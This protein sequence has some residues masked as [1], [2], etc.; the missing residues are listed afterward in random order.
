[1]Y[2]VLGIKTAI[3][4]YQRIMHHPD[5]LK[6]NVTTAFLN[7]TF[8]TSDDVREHPLRD[9]ALIATA[10]HEYERLSSTSSPAPSPTSAPGSRW[11]SIGRNEGLQS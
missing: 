9:I 2:Q 11:K 6:G 5:F 7:E 10:I 3:P 1:E 8:S 4:F